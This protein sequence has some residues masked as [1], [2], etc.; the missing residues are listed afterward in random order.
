MAGYAEIPDRVTQVITFREAGGGRVEMV[1]L[2]VT[3]VP[4]RTVIRVRSSSKQ[5]W[6]CTQ[7]KWASSCGECRSR[8][9]SA[10]CP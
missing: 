6:R 10:P 5:C 8:G 3:S 4:V 2:I 9:C 7:W 1:A